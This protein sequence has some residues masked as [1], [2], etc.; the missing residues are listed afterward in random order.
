[1]TKTNPRLAKSP[2]D[3]LAALRAEAGLLGDDVPPGA[4][5]LKDWAERFNL[6]LPTA[7]NEVSRLVSRGLLCMGKKRI[8]CGFRSG[9]VKHYWKAANAKT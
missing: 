7:A 2:L 9:M 3:E 1:M 6:P 4:L 5:T 8:R